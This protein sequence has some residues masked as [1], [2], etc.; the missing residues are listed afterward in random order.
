MK[1]LQIILTA[2]ALSLILSACGESSDPESNETANTSEETIVSNEG[3]T[4][5]GGTDVN[6]GDAPADQGN[7]D[8]QTPVSPPPATQEQPVTPIPSEPV[9]P[10]QPSQPTKPAESTTPVETTT[11]PESAD[12]APEAVT[13]TTDTVAEESISAPVT[14]A[15]HLNSATISAANIVLNWSH[16]FDTPVGGYDVIID[17]L[18]MGTDRT[19]STA[20]TISGLDLAERHC[21]VIESR[22]TDVAEFPLSNEVCSEA[23]VAENQAPTIGGVPATS[24]DA[25]VAYRFTPVVDDADNDNLTFS[26]TN[27][28]AWA[29][30]NSTNGSLSG[31]PSAQDVGDYNNIRITVS[32]GTDS[33]NLAAFNV[34]VNTVEVVT[35]TG[36][37]LLRWMAP[38]TRTDGSS[39]SLSEI[40]GYHIY[41]GTN[42]DNLQMYVDVSQ[43]DLDRYT[44]DNLDLGDYYVA[45]AAYDQT[46]NA[47]GLSNVVQKSVVN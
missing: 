20:V 21:F 2:F 5:N 14:G 41:V 17:G 25:G 47:S 42:P 35:T 1:S 19:F 30:F 37:M 11:P 10:T 38:S 45:I 46:G 29:S 7:T 6:S 27:L 33:A 9:A 34:R 26:V 22:Y 31:T 32:D 3:E 44:I 13:D 28:P 8:T 36:S 12:P 24:V 23:Q 15:V 43:G 39:L 4:A 18:D 16:D 40:N